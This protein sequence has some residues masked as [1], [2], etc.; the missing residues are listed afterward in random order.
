MEGFKLA[1]KIGERTALNACRTAIQKKQTT[2]KKIGMTAKELRLDSYLTK[3]FE[4]IV[5]AIE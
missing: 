4:T 3:Y 5:G 1:S 2:L